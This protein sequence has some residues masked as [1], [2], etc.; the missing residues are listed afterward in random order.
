M[1]AYCSHSGGC[2]TLY[3]T[4]KKAGWKDKGRLSISKLKRGDILINPSRHVEIYTGEKDKY[5]NV[6]SVAAHDDRD[7]KSGDS[8][9]TEI[10]IAPTKYFS[11]TN[12]LRL[13]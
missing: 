3:N 7:G 8:S 5:G 6:L 10:S 12:V 11:W 2:T 1:N 4:L 13:E 9:G